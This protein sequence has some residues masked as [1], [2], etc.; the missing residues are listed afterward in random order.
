MVL[1]RFI[2]NITLATSPCDD[3]IQF[4]TGVPGD[5]PVD[6][7]LVIVKFKKTRLAILGV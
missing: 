6:L 7:C 3:L 4:S 1:S 5:I 2:L